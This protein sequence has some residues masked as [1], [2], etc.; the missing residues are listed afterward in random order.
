AQPIW[1]PGAM[2]VVDAATVSERLS[3][4]CD[5][6]ALSMTTALTLRPAAVVE[7]WLEGATLRTGAVARMERTGSGWRLLDAEDGVLAEAETVVLAA[8]WGNAA[9]LP[10]LN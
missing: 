1:S 9:L 4:A 10:G 2:A 3:E 8:G 6:S 7:P 5:I